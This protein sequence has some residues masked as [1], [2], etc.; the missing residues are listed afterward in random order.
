MKQIKLPNIRI[1]FKNE[2]N[3]IEAIVR[4]SQNRENTTEIKDLPTIL[5]LKDLKSE[6]KFLESLGLLYMKGNLII[7]SKK[8]EEFYF[9]ENK[10]FILKECLY[11]KW[12]SKRTI[13]ILKSNQKIS[14]EKLLKKLAN[15]KNI[16]F[17]ENRKKLQRL[18]AW[19]EYSKIILIKENQIIKFKEEYPPQQ[20]L[21]IYC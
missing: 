17:C 7:P 6:I 21:L 13:N 2:L 11:N 8:A 16:S 15:F 12:F 9:D 5:N 4:S 18:L 20:T 10:S 14:S 3:I 1:S 19:L